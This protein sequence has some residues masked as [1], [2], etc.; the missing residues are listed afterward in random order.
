MGKRFRQLVKSG[1]DDMRQDAVMQQFFMLVNN[2]L[3]AA[4]PT[5]K[6]SLHI[7]TYKV[8]AERVTHE[9]QPHTRLLTDVHM[10]Y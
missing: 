10:A 1:N 8:E 6:R 7:V 4:E 2:V 9:L 3:A 5:R